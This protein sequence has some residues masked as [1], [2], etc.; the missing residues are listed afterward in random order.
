MA[1]RRL[2]GRERDALA[3]T[4]GRYARFLGVPVTVAVRNLHSGRAVS[5]QTTRR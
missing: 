3:V 5:F 1:L 4:I 2:S